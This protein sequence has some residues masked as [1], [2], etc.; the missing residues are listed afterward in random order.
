LRLWA[1]VETIFEKRQSENEIYCIIQQKRLNKNEHSPE[2]CWS[3]VDSL[4]PVLRLIDILL[5]AVVFEWN[6]VVRK[7]NS[8]QLKYLN[9][10]IFA[11]FFTLTNLTGWQIFFAGD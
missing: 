7:K 1:K 2:K 5:K 10:P 4:L 9:N 8:G 6:V 11:V 3:D